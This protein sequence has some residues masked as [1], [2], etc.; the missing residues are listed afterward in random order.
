MMILSLAAL[1]LVLLLKK[2]G[3][4]AVDHSIAVE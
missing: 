2:S 1:P 4:A 3:P